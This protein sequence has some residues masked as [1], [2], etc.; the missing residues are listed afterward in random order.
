M[1]CQNILINI[2]ETASRNIGTIMN[3][4]YMDISTGEN[5][6]QFSLLTWNSF[7]GQFVHSVG[8][9]GIW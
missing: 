7:F 3:L 1:H 8:G 5:F 6:R 9:E 4:A 2:S